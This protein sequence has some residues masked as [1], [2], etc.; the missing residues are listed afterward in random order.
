M[1]G[2]LVVKRANRSTHHSDLNPESNQPA[3][4]VDGFDDPVGGLVDL[5]LGVVPSQAESQAA[6]RLL[7][8]KPDRPQDM[9]CARLG[10]GAGATAADGEFR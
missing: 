4:L 10:A 7:F 8:R 2:C 1:R 6:A 9:A 5:G 3:K